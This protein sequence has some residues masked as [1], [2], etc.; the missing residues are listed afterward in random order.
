MSSAQT[1]QVVV[2]TG[3]GAWTDIRLEVEYST[4][5]SNKSNVHLQLDQA[6]AELKERIGGGGD[7]GKNE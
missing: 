1:V 7:G 5:Y 2:Q 3:D 4:T 6:V